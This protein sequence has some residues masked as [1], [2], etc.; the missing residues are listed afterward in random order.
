MNDNINP[1]MGGEDF[2]AMLLERPGAY[3][4]LGQGEPD[5]PESN[6]NNGLHTPRYDF[7]DDGVVNNRDTRGL[8]HRCTYSRCGSN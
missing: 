5:I 3:I 2:G 8:V 1:S 6:C 7:N 4:I